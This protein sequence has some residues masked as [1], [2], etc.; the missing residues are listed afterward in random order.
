MDIERKS[1]ELTEGIY[2]NLPNHLDEIMEF[3]Q[4]DVALRRVLE[5]FLYPYESIAP[6]EVAAGALDFIVA[7]AVKKIVQHKLEGA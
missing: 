5:V 4:S 7:L 2:A 6:S 3:T 1:K